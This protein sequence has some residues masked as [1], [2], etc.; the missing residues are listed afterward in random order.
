MIFSCAN[1][2]FVAARL[3]QQELSYNEA[4][5]LFSEAINFQPNNAMFFG[6]RAECQFEI[7]NF[8]GALR[9]AKKS[10]SL[11]ENLEKGYI[12]QLKSYIALGNLSSPC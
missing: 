2:K 11:D 1:R 6:E 9:D 5:K 3:K 4:Y 8:E 7:E 12:Y 10:I